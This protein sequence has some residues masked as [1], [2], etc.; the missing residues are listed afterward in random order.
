MVNLFENIEPNIS[1]EN[2]LLKNKSYDIPEKVLDVLRNNL[3]KYSEHKTAK[4]YKRANHLLGNTNQPFPNLVMIKHYF[5]NI[6]KDNIDKVE[7]EL[8]GGDIMNKW[9]QNLI[10][11]EREKVKSTKVARTNS[12]MKG[13]FRKDVEDKD[14]DTGLGDTKRIMSTPDI[15]TNSA[16]LE[17]INKIKTLINKTK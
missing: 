4:G 17:D 7:Y 8:N 2:S 11:T 1:E 16:L 15:M 14:F 6:D 9:V 10:K 12:G 13:Q 3:K 5:D